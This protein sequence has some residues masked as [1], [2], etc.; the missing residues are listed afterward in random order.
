LRIVETET[1]KHQRNALESEI[2]NLGVQRL[3][4]PQPGIE[5]RFTRVH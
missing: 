4:P 2:D 1:L 3:E 5:I